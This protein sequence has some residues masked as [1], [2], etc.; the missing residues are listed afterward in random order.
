M[1]RSFAFFAFVAT[2]V[3]LFSAGCGS[4]TGLAPREE[5][6]C[7]DDRDCNAGFV[8]EAQVCVP[9]RRRPD[10]GPLP[11]GAVPEPMGECIFD[12]D[13]P[14]DFVCEVGICIPPTSSCGECPFP[15]EC[16]AGVCIAPGDGTG[17]VCEFDPECGDGF[18]CIAGRCTPDPRIPR[19]CLDGMTCP[20]G[21]MCSVDGRCICTRSA[22]CPLGT[23]CG[24]EGTC[25]P[26]DD[27][28]I[29]DEDCPAGLLCEAGECIDRTECDVVHPVLT[30]PRVWEVS[31]TYNF[32]EALPGWL[33][34]L[35]AAV[36]APFRFFS[37]SGPAPDFTGLPGFIE[38]RLWELLRDWIVDNVPASVVRA[39]GGIAALN[40]ILSTWLVSE[41][42]TLWDGGAVDVYRGQN[43]WTEVEFTYDGLRV[44]GSPEDIIDW[45]FTPREYDARALCG[46][47]YIERHDLNV[48]IG[49]II[50]W[51]VDA[52]IERA[53]GGRYDTAEEMLI[54]FGGVVCNEAGNIAADLARSLGISLISPSDADA[55]AT[56]ACNG[57]V[58]TLADPLIDALN[59]ARLNLDVVSL[60]GSAPI[61]SNR[62]LTPGTWEGS[63]IGGDFTGTWNA[64]R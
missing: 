16:R 23:I 8:C 40:D 1:R 59:D 30:S 50:A 9:P 33:D 37:G 41:Q 54:G 28:C 34:S 3:P 35:L 26:P 2:F 12:D 25:V 48:G 18:L 32:R 60:K 49:A 19:T 17:D 11:D 36:A 64:R 27:R 20:D 21:L 10:A 61:V 45:S 44:R 42:M 13:C 51:A 4:N 29:A 55:L 56:S 6:E 52:V 24:A 5:P 63:L 22:D 46:T 53:T 14:G 57:F 43:Q 38:D 39:M 58:R 47:F 31:S 15:N 62:S 7:Y